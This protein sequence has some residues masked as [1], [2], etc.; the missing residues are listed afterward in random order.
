MTP[1]QRHR[2]MAAIRSVNTKPEL[3]VRRHL[4]RLGFRYSLNSGRL[5]GH[6]D[7]VLR[8]YRTCIFVNGCFWHGHE[9]CRYFRIPKSN[10]DYWTRKIARN[11]ERDREELR[12]LE[13]RGWHCITVWECGLRNGR[14]EG[15]LESLV[16]ELR[17]IY[18]QD[19]SGD[20]PAAEKEPQA[21]GSETA[22]DHDHADGR[23][24]SA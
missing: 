5:P 17:R 21:G 6:P 1:E 22:K 23:S 12:Q 3:L 7:I 20:G 15:T 14:L 4:W 16:L 11:K 9:G 19:H 10:V 13:E 8:K 2:N 18:R 24:A